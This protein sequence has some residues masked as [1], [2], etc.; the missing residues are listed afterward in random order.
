LWQSAE[1]VATGA[2]TYEAFIVLKLDIVAIDLYRGEPMG[3]MPR[4]NG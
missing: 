3:A 4:H 1:R 2:I